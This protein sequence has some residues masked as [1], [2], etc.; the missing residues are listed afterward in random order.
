MICGGVWSGPALSVGGADGR[1]TERKRL[2]EEQR[3]GSSQG[4]LRGLVFR[5]IQPQTAQ[6]RHQIALRGPLPFRIRPEEDTRCR[7]IPGGIGLR[8]RSQRGGEMLSYGFSHQK[9]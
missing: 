5:H 2:L 1:P 8:G 3:P 4:F 9:K 7:L 6:I